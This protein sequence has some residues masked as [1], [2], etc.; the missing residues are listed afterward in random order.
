MKEVKMDRKEMEFLVELLALNK[1]KNADIL[2][3]RIKRAERPIK[4]S[5]AKGK[6][7]GL[8]QWVCDRI[9][10]LLNIPYDQKDDECL[11]HSREMGLS[12]QDVIL[13]GKAKEL[14]PFSIECKACESLAVPQWVAQAKS[15]VQDGTDWM[16]IFKKQSMGNIPYVVI[17]WDAFE[18]LY[19]KLLKMR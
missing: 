5:S 11:I 19:E 14:F 7:R 8:Q 15:N 18:K 17:S 12:G 4:P 1:D 10:K 6:G 9:S 2:M 13:R 3:K 16:L